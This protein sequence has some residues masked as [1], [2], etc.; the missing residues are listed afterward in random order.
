MGKIIISAALMM[1]SALV[2]AQSS[3]DG[4]PEQARPG[5]INQNE[6]IESDIGVSPQQMEDDRSEENLDDIEN[7]DASDMSTVPGTTPSTY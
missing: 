7:Q 5:T 1:I 6:A 4:A 3:M 2:L